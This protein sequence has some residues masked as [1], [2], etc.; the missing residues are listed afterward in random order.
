MSDPRCS[1]CLMPLAP[2]RMTCAG[3]G[4]P[5]GILGK[6]FCSEP[7][8]WRREQMWNAAFTSRIEKAETKPE[9]E[10]SPAEQA[11]STA[12]EKAIAAPAFLAKAQV[13]PEPAPAPVVDH[14]STVFASINDG[15]VR[16]GF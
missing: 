4:T 3:C 13:E 1:E 12:R 14:W 9:P 16:K 15:P 8:P 7:D 6:S 2:G 5:R 11:W 10:L